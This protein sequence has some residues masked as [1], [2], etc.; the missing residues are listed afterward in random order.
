M[1]QHLV[2]KYLGADGIGWLLNYTT[3]GTGVLKLLPLLTG[4]GDVPLEMVVNVT[5]N[6]SLGVAVPTLELGGLDTWAADPFRVE[7][8]VS[9]R[10]ALY[11]PRLTVAARVVFNLTA[12]DG[13]GEGG[14]VLS[15]YPLTST[16]TLTLDL[17]NATTTGWVDMVV[18]KPARGAVVPAPC[19]FDQV[20]NLSVPWLA[21]GVGGTRPEPFNATPMGFNSI[22][23][24]SPRVRPMGRTC[25]EPN[26]IKKNTHPKHI[27]ALLR[28]QAQRLR[29]TSPRP[30]TTRRS[31]S[32][33]T[34]R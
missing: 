11:S 10:S 27:T 2:S 28:E 12:H 4:G 21:V 17:A 5:D 31:T 14:D 18:A 33:S 16:L 23:S 7:G 8:P 19:Y 6:V 20:R 1:V 3:N 24:G 30:T 29:L 22:S 26:E 32:R 25:G 15:R 13:T 9:L 34:R